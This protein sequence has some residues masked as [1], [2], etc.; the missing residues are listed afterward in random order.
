MAIPK[1]LLR[2]EFPHFSLGDPLTVTYNE[3][4]DVNMIVV[5]R[6]FVITDPEER[7]ERFVSLVPAMFRVNGESSGEYITAEHPD[8][9]ANLLHINVDRIIL[10]NQ[11][12]SQPEE[13]EEE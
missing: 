9:S 5:G 6:E 3:S 2:G 10:I 13:Q 4:P 11:V 8:G 12:I 1:W 7:D